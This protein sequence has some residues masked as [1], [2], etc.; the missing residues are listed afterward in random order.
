MLEMGRRVKIHYVGTLDDG[1]V[2]DSSRDRGEPLEYL[3]GMHQLLPALDKVVC[4]MNVGERRT[5]RIPAQDAY[6]SYDETLIEKIPA[7]MVPDIDKMPRGR[8]ISMQAGETSFRTKLVKVEDGFAYFDD[9]H[10]LAGKD[11]TFDVELLEVCEFSGTAIEREQHAAG[12][13]C[14]C[15]QLKDQLSESLKKR[16]EAAAV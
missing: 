7:R 10:E 11:L 3:V 14:G 16:R 6:G 12:C 1:T 9:N 2:F 15:H 5:V 4:D 13:S 8:Y